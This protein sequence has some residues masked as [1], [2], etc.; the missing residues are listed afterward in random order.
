MWDRGLRVESSGDLVP[1]H[2]GQRGLRPQGY[3]DRVAVGGQDHRLVVG[4]AEHRPAADVVD[5]QQ[6]ATLAGELVA[7]EVEDR[8]G[9]VAGLGGEADDDGLGPGPLGGDLVQDVGVLGQLQARGGAVSGL[10]D[11]ALADRGRAV[12]GRG[13]GHHHRVGR[14]G[15][16][17]HGVAQLAGG[18][19][20]DHLDAGRVGQAHVG[21]DQGDL[22]AAGHRGP[23]Q[24]VALPARGA[25]AEEPDRVE[26]LAG[27]PG[28]DHDVPSGQVEPPVAAGRGCRSRPGTARPAPAAGPCRSP[29]RSAGPPPAPPPRLHGTGAWRRW[30]GWRRAPTSRCAS[31]ARRPPG[32]GPSGGCW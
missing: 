11:L 19:D 4:A 8:A 17:H 7:G 26:V 5:H 21:A 14:S 9:V 20:P 2:V 6:V 27:A 31:R 12:V 32:S 13:C 1:D 24:G 22:G 29:R 18:L 15:C 3:V 25:V 23:G 30:P 28:G 10:L 16:R